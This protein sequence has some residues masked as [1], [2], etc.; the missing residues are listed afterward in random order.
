MYKVSLSSLSSIIAT[1]V[2]GGEGAKFSQLSYWES[3]PRLSEQEATHFLL[4][5]FLA[6]DVAHQVGSCH[7][8]AKE[9]DSHISGRER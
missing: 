3:L 5:A 4:V 2:F 9:A 6:F 1:C 8:Q 7:H